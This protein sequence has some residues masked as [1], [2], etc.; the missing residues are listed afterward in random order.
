MVRGGEGLKG[1]RQSTPAIETEALP[2][3]SLN[4]EALTSFFR[5]GY[6]NAYLGDES[7]HQK[8]GRSSCVVL[9]KDLE[10][11]DR[12]TAVAL[13]A[14]HRILAMATSRDEVYRETRYDNAVRLLKDCTD[15]F[16]CEWLTI[17]QDYTRVQRAA[18]DAGLERANDG[19]LVDR[20]LTE[21][22]ERENYNLRYTDTGELLVTRFT[23]R[24]RP[25]YEQQ[26]WVHF[27]EE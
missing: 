27:P 25:D 9:L 18:S 16:G 13:V 15:K 4:A 5:S 17:G 20:L 7:L 2:V 12:L 26:L 3:E 6:G 21:E 10:R 19:L 22:G 23:S 14:K 11:R 8:I 1:K 24:F